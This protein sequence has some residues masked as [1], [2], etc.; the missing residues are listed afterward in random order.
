ME[1]IPIKERFRTERSGGLVIGFSGID[2]EKM[3]HFIH[4]NSVADLAN[5]ETVKALAT[6][7]DFLHGQEI[8]DIHGV[9][10]TEFTPMKVTAFVET[11]ATGRRT[12]VLEATPTGL[13]W[14]CT[15]A[16]NRARFCKHLVAT[17]LE[18][19]KKAP[20]PR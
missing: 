6:P 10:F 8:V 16:S 1:S 4:M 20:G 9:E 19:W 13:K 12:S 15:C 5:E 18:T 7:S 2:S 17:A 14:H 11:P 3:L